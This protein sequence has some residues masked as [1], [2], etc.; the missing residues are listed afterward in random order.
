MRLVH[1]PNIQIKFKE[2]RLP[3]PNAREDIKSDLP[4][5]SDCL[6]GA[7]VA[8]ERD[9][10]SNDSVASLDKREIFLRN[11][12]LGSS[13]VEEELDL[14]EEARLLVLIELGAKVLGINCSSLL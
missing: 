3:P 5:A 2:I 10:E 6:N 11:I 9:V 7:V 8:A 14:L 12:G 1:Q 13:T 4:V